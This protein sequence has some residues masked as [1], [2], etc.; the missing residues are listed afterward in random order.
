MGSS[1]LLLRHQSTAVHSPGYA[2]GVYHSVHRS[3]WCQRYSCHAGKRCRHGRVPTL[4]LVCNLSVQRMELVGSLADLGPAHIFWRLAQNFVDATKP[5]VHLDCRWLSHHRHG[6]SLPSRQP[7]NHRELMVRG[8]RAR[9]SNSHHDHD[10]TPRLSNQLRN[11]SHLLS[12]ALSGLQCN[13][14]SQQHHR[15]LEI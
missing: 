5:E 15:H 10:H 1:Q 4:L 7:W 3:L 13:R 2:V 12:Q 9:K 11:P 8:Q 6:I 14:W